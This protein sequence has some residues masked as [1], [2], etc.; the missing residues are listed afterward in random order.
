LFI[1]CSR[2]VSTAFPDHPPRRP[3]GARASQEPTLISIIRGYAVAE[4]NGKDVTP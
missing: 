2:A 3:L 4:A 1:D